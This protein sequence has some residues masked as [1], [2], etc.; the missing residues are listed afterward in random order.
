MDAFGLEALLRP[1]G[2]AAFARDH[3]AKAPFL[4]SR[5]DS[6]YYDGLFSLDDLDRFVA[7]RPSYTLAFAIDADRKI[8]TEE[9]A[10]I[11]GDIDPLRLFQCFENGATI[12]LREVEAY[13]PALARLCRSAQTGF[14][15]P[16]NTNVYWS[17]PGGRC[18]P[19]HYDAKDVF[20]LQ[21]SGS[22][23]WRVYRPHVELPLRHQHCYDAL[24]EEGLLADYTLRAGDLLYCPR[25]FS[26]FV[27]AEDEASLHISLT[28]FPYLWADL[29]N[30]ALVQLVE[31]DAAFRASLPAGFVTEDADAL[32]EQFA[33][34][35]KRFVSMAQLKP[36]R[37]ALARE[38]AASRPLREK[39]RESARAASALSLDSRIEADVDA[40]HL[41]EPG[42]DAVRLMGQ[43]K[44]ITFR[45]E[46][47]SDL[48]FALRTARYRGRDLPGDMDGEAKLDLLRTLARN[49]FV[50]VVE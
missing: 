22:K 1:V 9:Y 11:G 30:R 20:V 25:G 40:F 18:F 49:G 29:L 26:H 12:V 45:P 21:L 50:T 23:R 34:L 32:Q 8:A 6:N 17:P 24:P 47:Y 2:M 48:V 37:D 35:A 36:A 43:G 42:P 14:H 3:Y 27:A 4:A 13:F 5:G 15:A 10:E 19:I 41:V 46:T 39:A 16:F 38:L 7:C 28:S 31:R 44:E 33:D